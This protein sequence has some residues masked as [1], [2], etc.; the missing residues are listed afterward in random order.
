MATWAGAIRRARMSCLGVGRGSVS[1]WSTRGWKHR[2]VVLR[3]QP[4]R[5]YALERQHG[6]ERPEGRA[7][8]AERLDVGALQGGGRRVAGWHGGA[9]VASSRQVRAY[10][11][12]WQHGHQRPEG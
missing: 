9:V 12:Q 3:S 6:L 4:L 10:E 11:W 1:R 7:R 5:S 8:A 2:L